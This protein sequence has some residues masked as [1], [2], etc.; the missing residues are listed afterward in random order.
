M[1]EYGK[2]VTDSGRRFGWFPSE[3][4]FAELGYADDRTEEEKELEKKQR[5]RINAEDE[6]FIKTCYHSIPKRM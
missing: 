6:K 4:V 1:I 5:D 2:I 3:E